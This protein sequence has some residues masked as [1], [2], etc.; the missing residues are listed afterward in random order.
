MGGIRHTFVRSKSATP[1]A[2]LLAFFQKLLLFVNLTCTYYLAI[3]CGN[4]R[5]SPYNISGEGDV[6]RQALVLAVVCMV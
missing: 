5:I 6:C 3:K 2:Q 4:S 1:L